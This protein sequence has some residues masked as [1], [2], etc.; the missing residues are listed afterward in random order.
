MLVVLVSSVTWG[1]ALPEFGRP[2]QLSDSLQINSE[3]KVR[4]VT[5]KSEQDGIKDLKKLVMQS[6]VE[7][8]WVYL[9]KITTWIEVGTDEKAEIE[10]ITKEG[11]TYLKE[12]KVDEAIIWELAKTYAE[13]ILYH[14]HPFSSLRLRTTLN[15]MQTNSGKSVPKEIITEERQKCLEED[16]RPSSQDVIY[17]FTLARRIHGINPYPDFS[18]KVVSRLGVTEQKINSSALEWDP[19]KAQRLLPMLLGFYQ[20][21]QTNAMSEGGVSPEGFCQ[22]VT[23]LGVELEFKSYKRLGINN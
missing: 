2:N 22:S 12:A 3:N 18:A 21:A 17:A 16:A 14:L 13:L 19:E 23:S 20:T 5:L 8:A 4:Y 7:E 11:R 10:T 15:L 1:G 9:P 6:K